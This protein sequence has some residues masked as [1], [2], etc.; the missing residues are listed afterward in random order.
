M[1]K[2]L[3][4]CGIL[5]LASVVAYALQDI[6]E[7]LVNA[8]MLAFGYGATMALFASITIDLAVWF[9]SWVPVPAK[10]EYISDED[11]VRMIREIRGGSGDL[12]WTVGKINPEIVADLSQSDRRDLLKLH[13]L[14]EQA[15]S[16][17]VHMWE[18]QHDAI[19]GDMRK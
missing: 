10:P 2:V 19:Y 7:I 1:K 12:T 17:S 16:Q 18:I 11:A 3:A 4:V 13:K 15:K 5:L 6:G 8:R 14:I 9:W